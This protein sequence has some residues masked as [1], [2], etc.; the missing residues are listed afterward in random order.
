MVEMMIYKEKIER[1]TIDLDTLEQDK[2]QHCLET[3]EDN[4]FT[5]DTNIT[6]S[7]SGRG[8]HII[9]WHNNGGVPFKKLLEIRRIAGDDKI[10][11]D[12]D[13]IGDR[14]IQVLFTYKMKKVNKKM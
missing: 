7:P 6:I 4:G 3:L 8:Y 14:A 13:A 12:L 10:R 5:E 11:V 1:I 2:L 9:A